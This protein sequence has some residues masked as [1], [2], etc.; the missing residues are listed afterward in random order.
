MYA[1]ERWVVFVIWRKTIFFTSIIRRY[2]EGYFSPNYKLTIGVDFALK[3]LDWDE[4]TK[5][6]LQLWDIAGHER[7]GHMTR[8]YYKYA[9]AAII[10]FDLSRPTTFESVLKWYNDVNE[11]VM[12]ADQQPIPV[13]LLA[14]KCDID[15]STFDKSSLEQFCKQHKFI[16]WFETS[17][18]LDKNIGKYNI[19]INNIVTCKQ[20]CINLS[21]NS[22]I[23]EA[24]QFL[25]SHILKLSSEGQKRDESAISLDDD[26]LEDDEEEVQ[27]QEER[28]PSGCCS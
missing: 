5:I 24:M 7:F 17:A 8:V 28:K 12:L 9:I 25:V 4:Q 18:K 3:S 21:I 10:V 16:G 13:I 20:P 6:N 26:P 27:P 2:T 23:D 15:D 14:N 1:N 22:I 11:K 19:I